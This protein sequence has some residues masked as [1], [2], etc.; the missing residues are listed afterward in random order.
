M[1]T[2]YIVIFLLAFIIFVSSSITA[3]ELSQTEEKSA[4]GRKLMQVSTNPA[5]G[6]SRTYKRCLPPSPK[7]KCRRTPYKRN[8]GP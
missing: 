8:C 4:L 7:K 3:R 2:F 6:K 1:K 5:C